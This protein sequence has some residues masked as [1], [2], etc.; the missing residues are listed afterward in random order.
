MKLLVDQNLSAR[1]VSGLGG[2]FP[3]SSHVRDLGLA[4]AED[5]VVWD[6][7]KRNGFVIQS[8]DSDFRQLSFLYGPPPKV[9]WLRLGNCGTQVAADTLLSSLDAIRDFETD[10]YEALLVLDPIE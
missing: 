10:P 3:D 1:L 4:A 6:Y 7:A 8:K 2:A 5:L 9:I